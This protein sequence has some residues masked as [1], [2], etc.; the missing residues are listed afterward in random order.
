MLCA[1]GG[2]GRNPRGK[3]WYE[4]NGLRETSAKIAQGQA[5]YAKQLI[6]AG[7]TILAVIGVEFSPA[8]ATSYLNKGRSIY[9]DQGIYTEELKKELERLDLAIPFIGVNQRALRKLDRQLNELLQG[10]SG[11]SV[12]P[13]A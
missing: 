13:A 6:D 11:D 8:C 5:A 12:H 2:P 9:R 10:A 3:A 7:C 1:S 4:K